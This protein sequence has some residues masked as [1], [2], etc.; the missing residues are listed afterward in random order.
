M[1]E[2]KEAG[3]RPFVSRKLVRG[4]T[5]GALLLSS[6]AAESTAE[7]ANWLK[8]AF[9]HPTCYSFVPVAGYLNFA[10]FNVSPGQDACARNLTTYGADG[11]LADDFFLYGSP[12]SSSNYV[13]QRMAPNAVL[14]WYTGTGCTGPR[15]PIFDTFTTTV[16]RLS[17]KYNSNATC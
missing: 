2:G 12:V 8:D 3:K 6:M 17:Y 1:M 11:N 14:Y 5:V 16:S 9:N 7:A 13:S 15:Q 4:G 10:K